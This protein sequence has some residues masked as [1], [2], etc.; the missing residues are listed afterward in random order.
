M[1]DYRHIEELLLELRLGSG[2]YLIIPLGLIS[3]KCTQAKKLCFTE[4]INRK[5]ETRANIS[6]I[7][8]EF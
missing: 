6:P 2:F 4:K 1:S 8:T 7:L 5:L 3:R